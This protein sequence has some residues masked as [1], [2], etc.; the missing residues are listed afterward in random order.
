VAVELAVVV[1]V[2][3]ISFAVGDRVAV[4]E[5][6]CVVGGLVGGGVLVANA[7]VRVEVGVGVNVE[8]F[9]TAGVGVKNGDAPEGVGVNRKT[10]VITGSP[11]STCPSSRRITFNTAGSI[12]ATFSKGQ[13]P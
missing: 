1:L 6:V 12:G 8:R 13:R 10:P 11:P 9:G 3:A 7:G 4:G 2:E 5:L